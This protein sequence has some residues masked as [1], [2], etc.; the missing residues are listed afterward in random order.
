VRKVTCGKNE[1][2]ALFVFLILSISTI[3]CGDATKDELGFVVIETPLI[4]SPIPGS[5]LA[6]SN[7]TFTWDSGDDEYWL[8][9]GTSQGGRQI[10]DSGSL[11]VATSFEVFCLPTSPTTIWVRHFMKNSGVWSYDDQSYTTCD[12]CVSTCL[13]LTSP[14]PETQLTTTTPTFSWDSG[15]SQYWLWIGTSIGGRQILDS[16]N[17]GTST[18]LGVLGL[19][20]NSEDLYARFWN[21]RNGAWF[22][23]DYHYNACDLCSETKIELTSPVPGTQFTESIVTFSWDSGADLYWLWVGTT[24]GGRE[25]VDS[26]NL[27]TSTSQDIYALPIGE[28]D[29]WVR[30]WFRYNGSWYNEDYQYSACNACTASDLDI[31]TPVEGSV[32]DGSTQTFTWESGADEYYMWVGTSQ[33]GRELLDSGS[34]GTSTST[35]VDNLPTDGSTVWVRFW[36][37]YGA[38]WY[39]VDHYYTSAFGLLVLS[40]VFYD[41]SGT[42]DGWE[43]IEIYNGTDS[44]IDLSGYSMGGGGTDYTVIPIQLSGTIPAGSCWVI[45]GPDSGSNNGNPVFDLET[46]FTPDLQNSG[47]AGDGIALFD[48]VSA[49]VTSL[50]VPIDAVIYGPNNDNGLLDESGSAGD[51]DVGDAPSGSSIERTASGWQIQAT[52]TPNICSE[53]Q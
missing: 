42:D 5:T 44:A 3:G 1:F 7:V 53:I 12:G 36:Y 40:E 41:N 30:L 39:Y 25:I 49:Q 22:F 20:N 26:G 6:T 8:W 23:E 35:D 2:V 52:P 16:G 11:G 51:P 34:L 31:L 47:T 21:R 29:V 9:V 38:P 15:A 45:G 19:P 18:S 28:E 46:N 33:G 24:I 4:T 27:G 13:E 17:L 37:R 48:V 43:W 32:L 10:L 14:I 50:T